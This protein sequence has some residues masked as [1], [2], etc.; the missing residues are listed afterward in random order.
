MKKFLEEYRELKKKGL[1]STGG[2]IIMF[3][4][5]TFYI[6]F[7]LYSYYLLQENYII[8]SEGKS[9]MM[10][11]IRDI[12]MHFLITLSLFYLVY[13]AFHKEKFIYFFIHAFIS[14]ILINLGGFFSMFLMDTVVILNH[15]VYSIGETGGFTPL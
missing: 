15:V 1:F 11:I 9:N 13:L 4:P 10:L 8:E 12:S 5:V 3:L 7:F 14:V 2:K 6:L